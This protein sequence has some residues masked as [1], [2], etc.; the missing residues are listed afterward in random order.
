MG[1]TTYRRLRE[2]FQRGERQAGSPDP[3]RQAEDYWRTPAPGVS[4]AAARN[5]ARLA[6]FRTMDPATLR[7]AAAADQVGSVWSGRAMTVEDAA[8]L[9]SP[10]YAPSADRAAQLKQQAAEIT[11]AIER[12]EQAWRF[13]GEEGERRRRDIGFVRQAMHRSGGHAD[14][15][16]QQSENGP[17]RAAAELQILR[18]H[19]AALARQLPD[20]EQQATAAFARARPHAIAELARRQERA[21]L[22]RTVL[23]E[24]EQ[25]ERAQRRAQGHERRRGGIWGWGGKRDG[26]AT[27]WSS[28]T[29]P[30]VTVRQARLL[31]PHHLLHVMHD[32]KQQ[33]TTG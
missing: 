16:P 3:D 12:S 23:E 26:P 6:E 20:A 24:R 4:P 28:P 22:A 14:P 18:P 11:A 19:S 15:W 10:A 33:R 13:H 21:G 30:V 9:V 8:R 5:D 25:H 1:V 17:R 31:S 2:A 32:E 7:E 27:R 29:G